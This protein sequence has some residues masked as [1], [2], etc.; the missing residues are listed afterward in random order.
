[1]TQVIW[2]EEV[3]LSDTNEG[4]QIFNKETN[5]NFLEAQV[6]VRNKFV[7]GISE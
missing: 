3:G 5:S 4:S 6:W 1:M 2:I 7:V